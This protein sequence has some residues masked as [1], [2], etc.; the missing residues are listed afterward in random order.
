VAV[1]AGVGVAVAVA[2]GAGVAVGVGVGVGGIGVGGVVVRL[3]SDAHAAKT[4][5]NETIA[6]TNLDS[7]IN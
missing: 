4:N 6:I 7:L 1:G 5:S 3:T 2:V